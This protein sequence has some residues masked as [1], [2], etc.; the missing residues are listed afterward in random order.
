MFHYQKDID[1]WRRHTRRLSLAEKGVY[2]ELLDELYATEQ[3]LPNDVEELYR[4]A[5]CA[6][7]DE[8]KVVDKI[9][10][11][12]FE[13]TD[14]GY[15]QARAFEEIAEYQANAEKNRNNG[16]KGGRPPKNKNPDETQTKPSG[17]FLGSKNTPK[18]A[19][20]ENPNERQS[21]NPVIR[22]SNTQ[23]SIAVIDDD[24]TPNSGNRVPV[25]SWHP[26]DQEFIR[27]ELEHDIPVEFSRGVF[28]EWQAFNVDKAPQST[29]TW[30]SRFLD[31]VHEQWARKQN[32]RSVS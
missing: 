16:K 32:I 13:L 25:A 7:P 10:S 18:N 4:I 27:L 6:K 30:H 31:R 24:D 2:G 20:F 14:I 8:R 23:S 26:A 1:A 19:D 3:P 9:I 15:V 22:K 29:S 17:L 11:R 12:F 5:G 21:G 28:D